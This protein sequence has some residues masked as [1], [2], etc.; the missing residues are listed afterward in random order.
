[1]DKTLKK[2]AYILLTLLV[3]YAVSGFFIVP[4]VL[5]A[6][7]PEL[8]EQ[9]TGRSASIEKIKLNPFT[10]ELTLDNFVLHERDAQ[11]FTRFAQFYLNFNGLQSIR[12][13]ALVVDSVILEKP[14]VRIARDKKKG[15]NFDD[16]AK[17]DD[18]PEPED[19]QA[20]DLFPFLIHQLKLT[21]G[22][23][24][25]HDASQPIPEKET[26]VP[27]SLNLSELS[28][29]TSIPAKLDLNFAIQSGG[30]FYLASRGCT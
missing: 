23:I 15:F 4:A 8:I 12:H 27:L 2:S 14:F 7:I 21:E 16:L 26:L 30:G 17:A 20:K 11:D 22:Q 28:T 29:L 19:E 6:K 18:V 10:L 9:E 25:W 5:K 1:M 24:D 13:I 3:L